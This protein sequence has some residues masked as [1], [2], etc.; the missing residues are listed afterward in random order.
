M[1]SEGFL[2][3][4]R[5]LP[6]QVYYLCIMR[7]VA[8]IGLM[9]IMPFISVICTER[10]GF[11]TIEAGIITALI[12]FGNILG[13][14]AGGK[15][16][17]SIGRRTTIIITIVL[18][19]VI[20]G[21]GGLFSNSRILLPFMMLGFVANAAMIPPMMA[22]IIDVTDESN[23]DIAIS[24]QMITGNVGIAV[25]PII[26]GLLFYRHM[27]LSF[28]CVSIF[29]A[30]ALVLT[31][32]KI[33]EMNPAFIKGAAA[34]GA[35]LSEEAATVPTETDPEAGDSIIKV[36]LRRPVLMVFL[37]CLLVL[38]LCYT[39]ISYLLPIQYNDMVGLEESSHLVTLIWSGSGIV[40]IFFTP[41]LMTFIKKHS[42][43]VNMTIGSFTYFAGFLLF[44][45]PAKSSL[46]LLSTF[47]WTCGEVMINTEAS[48]YTAAKTPV[49]HRGRA[50]SVLEFIRGIGRMAGPV[51]SSF[52]LL[53]MTY[54]VLWIG[55]S[56]V[57]LAV[58]GI[59]ALMVVKTGDGW[60]RREGN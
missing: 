41:F 38:V 31:F 17:D 4:Y 16:A 35:D 18:V 1:K 44:A 53:A 5:G 21:M 27:D 50:M 46:I 20:E 29:C 10:M 49:S 59:L 28:Y 39:E 60:R 54:Q 42:S 13:A 7:L 22:A 23:R 48:V 11:S 12:S 40:V 36:V 24:L 6:K 45:A 15:L 51:L 47:I 58:T 33:R 19:M 9:F 43:L 3:Q 14:M 57:C 8:E 34:E 52:L 2:G 26:G 32:A 30:A 56:F 55:I 37:L 25:G